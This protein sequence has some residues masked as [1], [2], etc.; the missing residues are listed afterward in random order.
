VWRCPKL[1]PFR[2]KWTILQI[3]PD[4]VCERRGSPETPASGSRVFQTSAKRA[5]SFTIGK[6]TR[7]FLRCDSDTYPAPD[8]EP[9]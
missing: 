1:R 4:E 3:L 7:Q 8:A 9:E 2:F 6:C 5:S